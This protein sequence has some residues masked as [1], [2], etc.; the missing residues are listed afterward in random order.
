MILIIII[1][2]LICFEI[3]RKKVYCGGAAAQNNKERKA[4]L[5]Y[6]KEAVAATKPVRYY[7]DL[8][9]S[10]KYGDYGIP[11]KNCHIGQRK[12]LLNEIQ[13]LT[14]AR[15]QN[16]II[17]YVGAAPCEHL[18][19][20][21]SLFPGNKYLL[22]D[23]NYCIIDAPAVCVYQNP[24]VIS[25]NARRI[26]KVYAKGEPHQRRGVENLRSM[27]M[28]NGEKI[29]MLK[30]TQ[31][32]DFKG[33]IFQ[34]MS[35]SEDSIFIIQDY[36]TLELAELIKDKRH[37]LLFISD[38]RTNLWSESGPVDMD[39]FLNDCL[40]IAALDILRPELSMLK[41]HPPYFA[42]EW[43]RFSEEFGP[44]H[45]HYKI[46]EYASRVAGH[47][48]MKEHLKGRHF[49]YRGEHILLQPWAPTSSSEARL[50]VSKNAIEERD[51]IE[52]D[53]HEWENKFFVL[54]YIRMYSRFDDFLDIG[55]GYD[56]CLDCFIELS[57]L[58][59]YDPR[60]IKQTARLINQH[61][62]YD[63]DKKKNKACEHHG[64]LPSLIK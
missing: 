56:G 40:Q 22:V 11:K 62:R 14:H 36:M 20:I 39:I 7:E 59:D 43:R 53:S 55:L 24:E 31:K 8:I 9:F 45:P 19:I 6:I 1:L 23:P 34:R 58:R 2:I 47:D 48:L 63:L 25:D 54:S 51:L 30:N 38:L 18:T 10:Y 12:L 35:E 5:K 42:P 44:D 21:Q 60:R 52:Y 17:L 46:I 3:P 16:S 28:L 37:K 41:F 13:F 27:R 57:I 49:N 26:V 29:D 32:H 4:A 33:D 64:K 15:P 50:V 61:L